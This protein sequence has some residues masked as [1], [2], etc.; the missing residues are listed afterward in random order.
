[1][2]TLHYRLG[3]FLAQLPGVPKRGA[4]EAAIDILRQA[5]AFRRP[6]EWWPAADEIPVKYGSMVLVYPAG[7]RVLVAAYQ[8]GQLPMRKGA[9]SSNLSKS[10]TDWI[11]LKDV[12][13]DT[14]VESLPTSHELLRELEAL[15]WGRCPYKDGDARREWL[16]AHPLRHRGV[17]FLK[18]GRG[19]VSN[20]G[21]SV[22]ARWTDY[23][24]SD[25]STYAADRPSP[26]RIN[27]PD[28]NW[29]LGR[30]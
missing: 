30:E 2:A 16:E 25:G 20:S 3:H 23:F 24:G 15:R 7:G 11:A 14:I 8:E 1:M 19:M 5:D 9:Q 4:Q 22:V 18:D 26:N 17:T 13:M 28:R 21:K 27:D 29:G 6:S 10:L 12:E